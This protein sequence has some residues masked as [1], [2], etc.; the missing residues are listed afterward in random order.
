MPTKP[1]PF[2][3][4]VNPDDFMSDML[5]VEERIR[6]I[7]G[8]AATELSANL[9]IAGGNVLPSLG[10]P[11]P[12]ASDGMEAHV[13]SPSKAW[14]AR[15]FDKGTKDHG[16]TKKSYMVFYYP[17]VKQFIHKR[18]VHGIKASNFTQ[19]AMDATEGSLHATIER[20]IT[21]GI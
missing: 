10:A 18:T 16:P 15:W 1:M 20:L 21:E 11:W 9:S 12:V 4:N 19:E 13:M 8:I 2:V 17:N 14:Y 6:R 3:I 5:A 7:V